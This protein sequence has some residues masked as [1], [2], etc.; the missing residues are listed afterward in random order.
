M[1]KEL[2]VN[3]TSLENRLAIVEDDQI[4]EI[5][6]ERQ[7]NKGIL[8][9]IY[10]GRV[11]KVLPGMQAAFVDIGLERHAF[12]YVSDFF[13]DY[14][15]YEELFRSAE[16]AGLE[17]A[18][19]LEPKAEAR[20]EA[21]VPAAAEDLKRTR[22][23]RRGRREPGRERERE[24]REQPREEARDIS[25]R[26]AVREA[27][28]E[29]PREAIREQARETPRET[30]REQARETP[31]EAIREQAA[32]E[33]PRE[34][35]REQTREGSREQRR[36]HFREPRES[37]RRGRESRFESSEGV[38]GVEHHIE[39]LPGESFAHLS[40]MPQLPTVVETQVNQPEE[41]AIWD[42]MFE[43]LNKSE[44]RTSETVSEP[45]KKEAAAAEEPEKLESRAMVQAPE[46]APVPGV[47]QDVTPAPE[48]ESRPEEPKATSK[49]KAEQPVEE[50]LPAP[51]PEPARPTRGRGSRKSEQPEPAVESEQA[52]PPEP[53][54]AERPE[55][56]GRKKAEPDSQASVEQKSDTQELAG[57]PESN[58]K[59]RTSG[60]TNGRAQIGDLLRE[61]QEILVQVAKEPIG[62]KGARIT[63]HIALPGRYLVFMPTVDHVGVSRK[64]ASETERQ[65]LK[66][67]I[68]RLRGEFGKG[69]IVRTVGENHTEE[70]FRADM[71]YLTKTWED[72]RAKAERASAPALVHSEPSLVQRVVRDYFN[73]GYKA[74]RVDDEHEYE[75]I[76]EFVSRFNPELVNRVRLYNRTEP[77]FDQY[78]ITAEIEKAL[79]QKVWL[80][81]GGY[82]VLNQT[83][84]LVAIDVNTGKFVGSTNSLEDTI[85]RTNLD[86]VKEVV[87]QIRLR[88]LGGIIVI[89]FIDMD[90]RRNRQKVMEALQQELSKDKSPSKILQFNEFGLVAITRKRVKQS[91]ERTLCQPCQT[92]NGT[93]MTK[94]VRTI[95]YSIHQEVRKLLPLLQ[96][97]EE[98]II[99]CHPDVS[100]S[101]RDGEREVLTEIEDLT[102][103]I[104][105]IKADPL[106]H[107]EQ[108]DIV[109][110]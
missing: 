78:G 10:K 6:I 101:L 93:G 65:R 34:T 79:K 105:T 104:V 17:E 55:G 2:I 38:G 98:L 95:C 24:P 92:C 49:A 87:R 1:S 26:E 81:N 33:T 46:E 110:G 16:S 103:K 36:E 107:V 5:F 3:S 73:D 70:D 96:E 86:A 30:S 64:I 72:L 14:E 41:L 67:I 66:E 35:S 54:P 42:P 20:A 60:R 22:R 71:T 4:T 68:H 21:A 97:G 83:E 82:I 106:M 39:P 109:E 57:R 19:R 27:P 7:K 89:D 32:R 43:Q 90:E 94:S 52:S 61:G 13:E 8:G 15:E 50:T 25:P 108:F 59:R 62:K 18:I 51:E 28:R 80:K 9:N 11:T 75:K 53:E 76:V 85:T 44:Q 69:F 48:P 99:R 56:R 45:E 47:S 91:L 102:R 31:K 88:D 58:R 29:T 74:V 12:L 63:S 100:K 23:S 84:A 77:I 37:G 40:T